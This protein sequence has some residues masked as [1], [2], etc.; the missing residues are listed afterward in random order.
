MSYQISGKKVGPIGFGMMNLTI[1]NPPTP[2]EDCFAIMKKALAGGANF[3]N[4]GELY[5]PAGATSLELLRAYFE[6]YPEDR[7]KVVISVKSCFNFAKYQ[8]LVDAASV[9]ENIEKCLKI[10]DGKYFIDVFE[11]ARMNPSQV[12]VEE[13][14][15]AVAEYVKAGKIG[16]IGL[17]EVDG[18]IIQQAVKVH[19]IAAVEVELSLFSTDVIENGTAA[20]CKQHNIPLVAYS[21]LSRGILSGQ[22]RKYE[23]MP[24]ND[25]RRNYPRYFPENFAKNIKL[26][27]KLDQLAQKH[28]YTTAQV[29][30]G[31]VS[32]LSDRENM[33]TVIPIPGS[34]TLPRTEENTKL[35]K[36]S[37]GE[38]HDLDKLLEDITGSVV[39]GRYPGH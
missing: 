37:Q 16:G 34:T 14:V 4:A 22:I 36:F 28:G 15:G 23:D 29:A 10:A 30:I 13:T 19:P 24:E 20:A 12:P 31:W 18:D 26:V 5:G 27:E 9:R 38:L 21:P 3:W 1:R 35:V 25:S 32:S 17:S 33:P 8:P 2:Y 7:E 6:K 11:P 39:G